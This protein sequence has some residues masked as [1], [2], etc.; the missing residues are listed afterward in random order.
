MSAD[1]HP[2]KIRFANFDP[3]PK[4]EGEKARRKPESLLREAQTA[5]SPCGEWRFRLS[6]EWRRGCTLGGGGE[7]GR[8]RWA[9]KKFRRFGI[10]GGNGV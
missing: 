7:S 2:P 10:F 6:P 9:I 4:A 3:P 8:I 1:F 5:D